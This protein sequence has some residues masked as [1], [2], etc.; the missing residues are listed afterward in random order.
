MPHKKKHHKNKSCKDSHSDDCCPDTPC[1]NIISLSES[2]TIPKLF[3]YDKCL[4]NVN[5]SILAFNSFNEITISSTPGYVKTNGVA[6]GPSGSVLSTSPLSSVIKIGT[7]QELLSQGFVMPRNGLI[8]SLA[9][10]FTSTVDTVTTD[11]IILFAEIYG[12]QAKNT[13]AFFAEVEASLTTAT[14]I[15]GTPTSPV[16]AGT[17]FT[18]ICRIQIKVQAGDRLIVVFGGISQTPFTTSDFITGYLYAS[19]TIGNY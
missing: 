16:S 14:Q 9:F 3:S 8:Q 17:V 13:E 1:Q 15:L 11:K 4:K 19:L 2:H 12:S 5:G 7:N 10:A 18:G 6:I